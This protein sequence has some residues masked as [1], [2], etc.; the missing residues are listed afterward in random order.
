MAND[1]K[2][3]LSGGVVRIT[4]TR[5]EWQEYMVSVG[6]RTLTYCIWQEAGNYSK[7]HENSVIRRGS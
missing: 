1:M 2:S 7:W 6:E 3:R 4:V 5:E